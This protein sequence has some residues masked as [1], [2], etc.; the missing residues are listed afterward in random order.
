M[1]A[2]G[3]IS[4]QVYR[5]SHTRGRCSSR[6]GPV[7]GAVSEVAVV[8]IP[9]VDSDTQGL[10]HIRLPRRP[11]D[12]HPP[13]RERR[14]D[15][16][17]RPS[18]GGLGWHTGEGVLLG[19]TASC[20]AGRASPRTCRLASAA[21]PPPHFRRGGGGLQGQAFGLGETLWRGPAAVSKARPGGARRAWRPC[22]VGPPHLQL[23]SGLC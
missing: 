5:V 17:Q 20:S 6:S 3:V 2:S 8:A 19:H 14:R 22:L 15:F 4:L 21:S 7:G 12:T 10:I 18:L 1:H 13:R 16:G 11:V 9:A 23:E